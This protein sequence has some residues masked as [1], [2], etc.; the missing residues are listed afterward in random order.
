M[1]RRRGNNEGSI[2]KRPDGSWTGQVSVGYDPIT[3]RRKRKS[4]YGRT[5]KEV[6]DKVAQA[7]RDVGNGIAVEP[8]R[9]SLGEWMDKWLV[10][11]KKSQ[12]KPSTYES[13]ESIIRA[14][15]KPSLGGI[16]LAK[17]QANML[18]N[19]YNERL[20]SG[21]STRTVRYTHAVSRQALQQAVKEG[22]LSRNV[23]DATTPPTVK[24]KQMQALSEDDLMALFEASKDDRFFPAYFL[25]ATTGM[26]R[27]ELL[28]LCWDSVDLEHGM[29]T[30]RRQLLPL[31]GGATLEE[32]TKTKQG[33]R[34]ISLTDDAIKVLAAQRQKQAQEKLRLGPAY[35]DKGLVFCREDGA[36]V[37]PRTFTKHFQRILQKAGLPKIRFHDLR[38]THASLLLSR[39]IHP[40]IVQERLGHSSITM[41]LDLYSH[42]TP[43]L[44]E[45]AASSLN[46]L[47]SKK[48]KGKDAKAKEA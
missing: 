18:Q 14:Y 40:K 6:S 8:T 13:Y 3:G 33:R 25:A 47:L 36:P 15:I 16:P 46:G 30:V 19:F 23:A 39:G 45:A 11:Y 38:H 7:L 26:R 5:R 4:F 12:L 35:Q 2:Y 29:V 22:L 17:V 43:G 31:K 27:A 9:T 28:G 42:L 1:T 32:T 37:D 10:R 24:S 34:S 21:L 44:Q 20:E 48:N 41:T